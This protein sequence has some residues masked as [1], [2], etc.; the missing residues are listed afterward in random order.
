MHSEA[1]TIEEFSPLNRLPDNKAGEIVL[2]AIDRAGGW[3][4]WANKDNFTF[5][6]II[7]QL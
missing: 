6:K 7:T 5:T 4:A 3:D 2:K 1:S